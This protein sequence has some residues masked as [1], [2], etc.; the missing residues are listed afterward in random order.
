[1]EVKVLIIELYLQRLYLRK[2]K[3]FDLLSMFKIWFD[4]DVIK[5]M[6]ISNFIDENQV[7]D[8]I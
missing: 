6:N 3:V 1:M 7:K 4:F 5:F 2:M 8:M